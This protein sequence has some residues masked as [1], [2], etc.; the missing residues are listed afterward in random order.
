MRCPDCGGETIPATG[1]SLA[2]T[3]VAGAW[4]L[5]RRCSKF[6]PAD[7]ATEGPRNPEAGEAFARWRRG[8]DVIDVASTIVSEVPTGEPVSDA[9]RDWYETGPVDY[10]RI[11]YR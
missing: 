9:P 2:G 11:R 4:G 3:P 6:V 10:G 7:G 1:R 5:C 8:Q